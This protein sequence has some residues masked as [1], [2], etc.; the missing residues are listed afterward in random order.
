MAQGQPGAEGRWSSRCLSP[1][2]PPRLPLQLCGLE[3]AGRQV[4]LTVCPPGPGC[5][6]LWRE[7]LSL[8]SP[9]PVLPC[10]SQATR[11]LGVS[12]SVFDLKSTSSTRTPPAPS[13]HCRT[14]HAWL[15][16]P[17]LGSGLASDGVSSSVHDDYLRNGLTARTR[18]IRAFA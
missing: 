3:A 5:S 6:C 15:L 11:D 17:P 18:P 16:G 2:P 7:V 9:P 8:C 13:P 10:I 12:Y 1:W 4:R 14:A